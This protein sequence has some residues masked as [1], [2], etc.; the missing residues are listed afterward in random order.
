M[1]F[2]RNLYYKYRHFILYGIIGGFCASLDFLLTVT[3]QHA[4]MNGLLANVI[5]V[6]SGITVSFFLNAFLNFKQTDS[7]LKRAASFYT[8]GLFGLGVSLIILIIGDITWGYSHPTTFFGIRLGTNQVADSTYDWH[9]IIVKLISVFAVA[10]L[11]FF[12]NKFITFRTYKK[13]QHE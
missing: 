12:L 5:G 4:G 6:V 3:L 2:I 13:Q 10:L 11:Q 1:G 9:Y 7:I 8:V